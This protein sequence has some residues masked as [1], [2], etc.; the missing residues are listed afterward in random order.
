MHEHQSQSGSDWHVPEHPAVPIC[1][2]HLPTSSPACLS[3]K[4]FM[5][6]ASRAG[7]TTD[8]AT[9]AANDASQRVHRIVMDHSLVELPDI[10]RGFELAHAESGEPG[11]PKESHRA[12]QTPGTRR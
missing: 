3:Q 4:Q 12:Y 7:V 1:D 11:S 8:P 9:S 10:L 6:F 2:L 5:H